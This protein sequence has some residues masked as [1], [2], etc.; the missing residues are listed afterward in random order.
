ML[1]EAIDKEGCKA[2]E[3]F[4]GGF[5]SFLRANKTEMPFVFISET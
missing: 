3:S 5:A 1:G 4:R 2:E